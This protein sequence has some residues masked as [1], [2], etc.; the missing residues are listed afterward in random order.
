MHYNWRSDPLEMDT[1]ITCNSYFTELFIFAFK[2]LIKLKK[3]FA[4]KF[5]NKSNE[6]TLIVLIA[7][8]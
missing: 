5:R 3:N 8:E 4:F 7:K 1:D 2:F 6:R